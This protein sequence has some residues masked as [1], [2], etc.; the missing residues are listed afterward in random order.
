MCVCVCRR[1]TLGGGGGKKS[2]PWICPPAKPLEADT[3]LP[4]PQSPPLLSNWI[5]E[6][7]AGVHGTS[8]LRAGVSTTQLR[9]QHQNC[10][11][12]VKEVGETLQRMACTEVEQ[13]LSNYWLYA[14]VL[15]HSCCRELYQMCQTDSEPRVCFCFHCPH[16]LQG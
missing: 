2:T 14:H 11:E 16:D 1:E 6:N 10:W 5:L 12:G 9:V 15:F 13:D 3:L 7:A 4:G 8:M